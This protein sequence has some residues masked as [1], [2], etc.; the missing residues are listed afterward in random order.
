MYKGMK[1]EESD[2]VLGQ[3]KPALI[4]GNVTSKN[5]DKNSI[6]INYE[7]LKNILCLCASM[8]GGYLKKSADVLKSHRYWRP[9]NWSYSQLWLL[10]IELKSPGIPG[11]TL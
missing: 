5:I 6:L 8:W 7:M 1:H 2:V 3:H 4:K 10:E 11:S 9:Q